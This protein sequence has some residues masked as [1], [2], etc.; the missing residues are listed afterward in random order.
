MALACEE[1]DQIEIIAKEF[2][3]QLGSRASTLMVE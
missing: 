3:R 1:H 2:C